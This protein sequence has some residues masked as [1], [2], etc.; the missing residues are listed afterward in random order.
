MCL[1][2]QGEDIADE[3]LKHLSGVKGSCDC[4]S[5]IESF[6][7]LEN[8]KV[9]LQ[10]A[11]DK[12]K[13]AEVFVESDVLARDK[14]RNA[15]LDATDQFLNSCSEENLGEKAYQLEKI[16]EVCDKLLANSLFRNVNSNKDD[17]N[18]LDIQGNRRSIE[19]VLAQW[20]KS[21]HKHNNELEQIRKDV[22]RELGECVG[23]YMT[24]LQDCQKENEGKKAFGDFIPLIVHSVE[25]LRE[26]AESALPFP[27]KEISLL[28]SS[29]KVRCN[30][31]LSSLMSLKDQES[32]VRKELEMWKN[33]IS[34]M[35]PT[36]EE[37]DNFSKALK[38]V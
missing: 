24:A 9:D 26:K 34:K 23:T 19:T 1:P 35:K 25:R 31:Q 12:L 15:V 2:P 18:S 36:E 38:K 33:V 17:D 11:Q 13:K 32:E 20:K 3:I 5:S 37:I 22:F 27:T 8:L 6:R 14:I 21:N 29:L 16:R 30:N 7:K 4:S 28:L 10:V